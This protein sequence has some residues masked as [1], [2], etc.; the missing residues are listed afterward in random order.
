[1][2]Q[3][4]NRVCRQDGVT[5]SEFNKA[6]LLFVLQASQSLNRIKSNTGTFMR[7]CVQSFDWEMLLSKKVCVCDECVCVFR[8][9]KINAHIYVDRS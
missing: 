1:M 5:D 8:Y 7:G 2:F 4:K 6:A 9:V 3:G